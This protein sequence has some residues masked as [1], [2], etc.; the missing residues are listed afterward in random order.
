[1]LSVQSKPQGQQQQ[2][3]Q[4]SH[5]TLKSS[6][7]GAGNLTS[8]ESVHGHQREVDG[9]GASNNPLDGQQLDRD[10]FS[11]D[12]FGGDL[13]EP[14][15]TSTALW[16]AMPAEDGY[17]DQLSDFEE[18][19][20]LSQTPSWQDNF[21]DAL[22][23]S[24]VDDEYLSDY[25]PSDLYDRNVIPESDL[26]DPELDENDPSDSELKDT[27]L[28][29]GE[30]LENI[31][32]EVSNQGPKDANTIVVYIKGTSRLLGKR[33]ADL[34]QL[35]QEKPTR[36]S[37]GEGSQR[38]PVELDSDGNDGEAGI[39]SLEG[40]YRT[41]SQLR[42]N[43]LQRHYKTPGTGPK[44]T[45][46]VR[47]SN[48]STV[49]SSS[50]TSD[51]FS[52]SASRLQQLQRDQ[53]LLHMLTSESTVAS[54]SSAC[55][56]LLVPVSQLQQLQ[57]DQQLLREEFERQREDLESLRKDLEWQKEEFKREKEEF[58]RQ[59]E[60]LERQRQT[61]SPSLSK[62]GSDVSVGPAPNQ[63]QTLGEGLALSRQRSDISLGLVPSLSQKLGEGP[64]LPR[65]GSDVSLGAVPSQGQRLQE[66][67]SLIRQGKEASSNLGPSLKQNL[68]ESPSLPRQGNSIDPR[69]APS[70]KQKLE[71][72]LAHSKQ[73]GKASLESPASQSQ[74]L[75]DKSSGMIWGSSSSS[76]EVVQEVAEVAPSGCK[77]ENNL[78][79]SREDLPLSYK[80][81][82]EGD[83][84]IKF[85]MDPPDPTKTADGLALSPEQ[86][87]VLD[88]V[89]THNKS[90][91]F[92]GSAG[93]GK[94][95]LLR[96]LIVR[97]R[98]KYSRQTPPDT[99]FWD[100][101]G[102]EKVA[103]TASTGIA[104]CNIGGC[105]LHSFAGIGLGNDTVEQLTKKVLSSKKTKRRWRHT[106]VLIID[107]VS[108][109]D[110]VLLDKL[111]AIARKVRQVPNE[112]EEA[113]GGLQIV[114]TGDFFQ[115]PPVAKRSIQFCFEAES[116]KSY[117]H[118]NIQ[119]EQVFRQKDP[120][121]ARMLNEAR[122]GQMQHPTIE[123]F[124]NLTRDLPET[125]GL[126]PTELFPLRRQVEEANASE[127][128]AL[129][130]ESLF[131]EAEDYGPQ[132][133]KLEQHCIAPTKLELKVG[134]QVM[135]L[136]NLHGGQGGLV[137]GSIGIV[138]EFTPQRSD[139]FRK[140]PSGQALPSLNSH[141]ELL[142]RVR[143]VMEG[144]RTRHMVVG[145]EEWTME[146]PGGEVIAKR[147]QIP[148]CLAWSLSIHKAQGQTLPKVRVDLGKVFEKGQAYVAMS[149]ATCLEGL[150]VLNFHPSKV[151]VHQK[152]ITFYDNLSREKE[153]VPGAQQ[154]WD[155]GQ[156]SNWV[157][158]ATRS[159]YWS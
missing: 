53:R 26:D 66:I 159:R 58:Q 134:A 97:L 121:F 35:D 23:E 93:T 123:Q 47:P 56:G 145:R 20:I 34:E 118:T 89:V 150:Q 157:P 57:R 12:D 99:Y 10:V 64:S 75:L 83:D 24:I 33:K 154:Q 3:E 147:T 21:D 81:D 139:N 113:W 41:D 152:V 101:I 100:S 74:S 14:V 104:A 105:T 76:S 29:E 133:E 90:V 92:T 85:E 4:Q 7:N 110:A 60:S 32:V 107:E 37:F 141:G 59:R 5:Q 22:L 82:T 112:E 91:F 156:T 155:S 130:S 44:Q 102:A 94:S 137:N 109:I 106:R 140:T 31:P 36:P 48:E 86:L 46:E 68:G 120:T 114:L 52:V 119:L 103:V 87:Y 77:S 16:N 128:N 65:Q 116:W 17:L 30:F 9:A 43:T 136:R 42:N 135:L 125:D 151:M 69:L 84:F 146:M 2:Q 111:E 88:Q 108:M 27:A 132:K 8:A 124:L 54:S 153:K 19:E 129:T 51:G 11:D 15:M 40:V 144:G 98:E 96:E 127:L 63:G 18:D 138:V 70:H 38:F 72:S 49:A 45:A 143:F 67:L 73:G 131:F 61:E 78:Q 13:P 148:L 142:P 50:S 80:I 126:K 28:A 122:I 39:Q 95:V 79:H 25:I 1:M 115:L 149:R 158:S 6:S 55:C 71:E 62:Q 117:I